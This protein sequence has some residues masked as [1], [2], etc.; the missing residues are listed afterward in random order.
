MNQGYSVEALPTNPADNYVSTRDTIQLMRRLVDESLSTFQIVQAASEV[1][2]RVGH[3]KPT[4]VDICRAVFWWVKGKVRLKEDEDT[5][6][7]HFGFTRESLI[8]S[9]GKELLISP[10]YLVTMSSPIG[11]C[12][13]FSTLVATLLI[14]LGI[15]RANIFFATIAADPLWPKNFS[16]VF[17]KVRLSNGQV[18]AMDT[19]HGLFPGWETKENYYEVDWKV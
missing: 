1:M 10:A 17:V 12:D 3:N 18:I 15:P 14:Q 11:D 9:N 6:I 13:D 7:N 2:E 19:S 4:D 8:A 5:L 16:H